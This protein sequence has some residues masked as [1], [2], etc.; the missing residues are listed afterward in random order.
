MN[1]IFQET[2]LAAREAALRDEEPMTVYRW[3]DGPEHSWQVYW[4][5]WLAVALWESG[6]EPL[7][8]QRNLVPILTCEPDGRVAWLNTDKPPPGGVP[9]GG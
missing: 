6:L 7:E 4:D 5:H 1:D 3:R 2:L 8:G 9:R